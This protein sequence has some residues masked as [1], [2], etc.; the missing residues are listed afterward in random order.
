MKC[1]DVSKSLKT[2]LN[3]GNIPLY[4]IPNK[5]QFNE[6]ALFFANALGYTLW[7]TKE[8]LIFDILNT[9]MLRTRNWINT[10]I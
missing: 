6:N 3:Y 5:G 10:A 1:Q 9:R 4:F 2:D 8:G 7:V